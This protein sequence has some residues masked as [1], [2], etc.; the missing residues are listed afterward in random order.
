MFGKTKTPA[1]YTI[2]TATAELDE[3]LAKAAADF[4]PADRLVDLMESRISGLRAR[5]VAA[6]SNGP[7]F[8]SGNI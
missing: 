6:Y 5:Q 7:A 4:V 1:T 8:V 3:I 2:A